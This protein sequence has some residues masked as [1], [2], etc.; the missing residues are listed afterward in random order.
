MALDVGLGLGGWRWRML[1]FEKD[2][3]YLSKVLTKYYH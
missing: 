3:K 1:E 2:M